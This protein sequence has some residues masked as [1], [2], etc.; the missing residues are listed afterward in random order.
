[1][2]RGCSGSRRQEEATNRKTA[3][4]FRFALRRRVEIALHLK[5]GAI[6]VRGYRRW[7]IASKAVWAR[8]ETVPVNFVFAGRVFAS[9]P[10]KAG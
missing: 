4:I 10:A 9:N 3:T 8:A 1:M 7:L 2:G 6:V 5:P